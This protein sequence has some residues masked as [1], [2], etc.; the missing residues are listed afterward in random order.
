MKKTHIVYTICILGVILLLGGLK[1]KNDRENVS[2]GEYSHWYYEEGMV[3]KI[4]GNDVELVLDNAGKDSFFPEKD[5]LKIDCKRCKQNTLDSLTEGSRVRFAFFKYN[6]DTQPLEIEQIES[7][8]SGTVTKKTEETFTIQTEDGTPI[9]CN[10]TK[11][12]SESE[13]EVGDSVRVNYEGG[14]LESYSARIKGTTLV[15]KE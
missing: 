7:V 5:E 9:V 4:D 12:G 1:W 11:Y 14:I 6:V 3:Q 10:W 8:V 15:V 13:I 2:G